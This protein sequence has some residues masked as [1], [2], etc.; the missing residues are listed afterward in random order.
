MRGRILASTRFRQTAKII[1]IMKMKEHIRNVGIV[2]H[3]DHGKTT[4]TDSLLAGVGLIS[5]KIAG[6]ARVLDYLEEEQ[7]RGITIKTANISLLHETNGKQY[8]INLVD[9]PGHVDFTGRVTRALRAIDGA[10]VVVDAV[11]EIMAQ[12]ETVTRQALEERVKPVLFINKVDRLIRELRLNPSEIQEKLKRIIREFNNLIEIYGEPEFVESWKV[13]PI[14]ESVAFGSALDGWGLTL[15]MARER[16]IKFSDIIDAYEKNRHESL[17]TFIP[18]PRV[19]LEMI[20]EKLPNPI[21]AQKYRLPKIWKG[22]LNSEVGRAMMACDDRGPTVIWVTMVQA[23]PNFGL[24]ATGRIFSGTVKAGKEVYLL[25]SGENH[26]VK[27]VFMYMGPFKESVSEMSAGN[28]VAIAGLDSARAGET[29]IDVAYKDET[30]HFEQIK[31]VSEPVM[32]IT[33]EPKNPADLPRLIETMRKIS[34]EDP[35][36]LISMNEET[37]EYLL[38]GVGELH[39]EVSLKFLRE[40]AG[41]MEI[42]ASKPG[43]VYRESVEEKGA[44]VSAESPNGQNKFLVRVEPLEEEF[45]NLIGKGEV[46]RELLIETGWAETEAKGILAFDKSGNVLLDLSGGIQG[47]D[48]VRKTV[49]NGFMWTCRAGPLCQEPIR[50]VKIKILEARIAD[51]VEHRGTAQILPALHHAIFESF[52]T[53]KPTLLE[54]IY[55][56]EVSVPVQWLGECL[57]IIKKKRGRVLSSEIKGILAVVKAYIP[58]AESFGLSTEMRSATAGRAFWQCTFHGWEKVP[59]DLMMK[60]VKQIRERKGLPIGGQYAQS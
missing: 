11:E 58:V 10:V 4:L 47:D 27:Q 26:R 15:K 36:I 32:T 30:A 12:T 51:S 24:V 56:I 3:I 22:N 18:L 13:D 28:I 35:N 16:G 34:I 39:L 20:I 40:Y 46:D 2:A 29:I 23:D 52:L 21:E 53:A 6:K 5:H 31:Y 33:V 49:I 44:T 14:N 43:V 50:G 25:N 1:E 42:V 55:R 45:I 19:I 54:P 59:K 38:S 7:K 9:T 60:I 57:N 41:G 17:E 48:E 37:G 8:V